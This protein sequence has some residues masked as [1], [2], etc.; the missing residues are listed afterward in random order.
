MSGTSQWT[1]AA[2]LAALALGLACG[3]KSVHAELVVPASP[4]RVWAV[5]TDTSAYGEWNPIFVSVVGELREGGPF[6]W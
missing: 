6:I 3:R 2:L 4:D 5:L 1:S